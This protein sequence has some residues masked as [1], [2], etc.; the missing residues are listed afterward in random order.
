[1]SE[2]PSGRWV[3]AQLN[4]ARLVAP[5]DSAELAGVVE[6][7]EPVNAVADAAPGF[8]WR[9]QDDE[10]DATSI[11]PWGDDVIVNMSV[12]RPRRRFIA[13]TVRRAWLDPRTFTT[14]LDRQVSP[15]RLKIFST[16]RTHLCYGQI[17]T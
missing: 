17:V 4:V 12:N 1:M 2:S 11:R 8:V 7:L 10:G 5:L 15:G 13:G 3:L 16:G 6:A 14:L 9:L